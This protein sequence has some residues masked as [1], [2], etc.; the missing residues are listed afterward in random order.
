MFRLEFVVAK[1]DQK[2]ESFEDIDSA[3]SNG[4]V[5]MAK[6]VT[7]LAMLYLMQDK[8]HQMKAVCYLD[9]A[10]ALDTKNQAN[11]IEIADQFGFALIFASPAPLTTAR[12]CVPIHQAN[13]KNHI[14]RA[15]WQIFEPIESQELPQSQVEPSL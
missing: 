5:L 4:T 1:I 6:L 10:L 11:L 15:S 13:G 3:A 2:E 8:R 12:Y 9:E 14:S 7:G